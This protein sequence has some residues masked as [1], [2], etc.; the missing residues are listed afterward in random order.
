MPDALET[1][2]SRMRKAHDSQIK[3]ALLPC[4]DVLVCYLKYGIFVLYDWNGENL[5]EK[6]NFGAWIEPDNLKAIAGFIN[7]IAR[8]KES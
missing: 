3:Y 4:E 1:V 6:I 2:I 8:E 7:D 5:E